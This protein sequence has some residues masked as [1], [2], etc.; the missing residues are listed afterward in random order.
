MTGYRHFYGLT[1]FRVPVYRSKALTLW[2]RTY[3]PSSSPGRNSRAWNEADDAVRHIG[4]N[5]IPMKGSMRMS[6]FPRAP[7]TP[8]SAP[9]PS[10]GKASTI[11]LPFPG[12]I[13]LA[14]WLCFR[15]C[16]HPNRCQCSLTF[17][18]YYLV[19]K[20][21]RHWLHGHQSHSRPAGCRQHVDCSTRYASSS[22]WHFPNG[23]SPAR[24]D[25][26]RLHS[27]AV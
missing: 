1:H 7:A 17:D 10:A 21:L 20:R 22:I 15:Q 24:C 3:A 11:R 14:G 26:P 13:A 5:C 18:T 27:K 19:G 23:K 9:T 8:V 4:T 12:P 2:L 6:Y 25:G 16:C